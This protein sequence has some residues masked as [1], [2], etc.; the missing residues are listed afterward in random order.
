MTENTT[1]LNKCI[2]ELSEMTTEQKV[3]YILQFA[4]LSLSFMGIYWH[5]FNIN[6]EEIHTRNT[7]DAFTIILLGL[8]GAMWF[9]IM[10]MG[11]E[12]DE[13]KKEKL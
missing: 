2:K 12:I 3:S 9:H 5:I 11:R 8:V 13:I 6:I 7:L 1:F 10:D 4:C